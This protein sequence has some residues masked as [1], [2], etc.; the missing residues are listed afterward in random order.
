MF[1]AYR[2]QAAVDGDPSHL[3]W[4]LINVALNE[5]DRGH[6]A[7]AR[8]LIG[9]ALRAADEGGS[10]P[11]EGDA[12]MAAGLV[13]LLVGGDPVAA[14]RYLS[15]AARMLQSS[16]LLLTLPDAISLL[17]AALLRTG[18]Q[19]PAARMLA[20]GS[21][22]RSGRGLVVV[23]RL[24]QNVITEAEAALAQVRLHAQGTALARSIDEE[25]ARGAAAPF[26]WLE[27]LDLPEPGVAGRVEIHLVDL[28]RP[29]AGATTGT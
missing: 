14:V 26:G 8:E 12:H 18:Q 29:A 10:T 19:P 2:R 22:W 7:L 11:I 1:E 15:Q 23:S 20:A 21:A 28:S 24:S 4:A 5:C 6:H 16:G 3:A 9:N 13:E 27:A 17:G 25:A